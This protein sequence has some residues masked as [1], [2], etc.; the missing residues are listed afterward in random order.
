MSGSD[1]APPLLGAGGSETPPAAEP[2]ATS[3]GAPGEAARPDR[4][5]LALLSR[6]LGDAAPRALAIA[7]EA[8]AGAP[9]GR[10]AQGGG[11]EDPLQ[12]ARAVNLGAVVAEAAMALPGAAATSEAPAPP[13][14]W[15]GRFVA[16]A[17]DAASAAERRLWGRVLAREI[18]TPDSVGRRALSVIPD[19]GPVGIALLE[20]A[21]RLRIGNFIVRLEE[22]ELAAHG[23]SLDD[24]MA[25]EEVGLLRGYRDL[26]KTFDS[27]RDDR[28]VTHLILADAVVRVTRDDPEARLVLPSL[29]F[30]GAGEQLARLLPRRGDLSYL[31]SVMRLIAERGF[32]VEHATV[33]AFAGENGVARHTPFCEFFLLD[34]S[35]RSRPERR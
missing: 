2:A 32:R 13:L 33:L 10:P 4:R 15:T 35:R 1:D 29:R 7:L 21:A 31:V 30:T 11:A 19:L 22:S 24:A 27:Q 9:A 18:T 34:R 26:T 25:L 23:L 12:R 5:S 8:A 17:R 3:L 16:G 6:R 14:A 20:R 28:F